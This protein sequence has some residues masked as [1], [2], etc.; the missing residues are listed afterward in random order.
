M[1]SGGACRNC[2]ESTQDNPRRGLQAAASAS[3]SS[4]PSPSLSLPLP[5]L[6]HSSFC[7]F[8]E[9]SEAEEL[10]SLQMK[11]SRCLKNRPPQGVKSAV[12]PGREATGRGVE[13]P[14]AAGPPLRCGRSTT[15]PVLPARQPPLPGSA[16]GPGLL[17]LLLSARLSAH[18]LPHSAVRVS[19]PC[20]SRSLADTISF[21]GLTFLNLFSISSKQK[22]TKK[23]GFQSSNPVS[24]SRS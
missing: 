13:P 11:G 18:C 6:I 8:G 24:G 5:R 16:S 10:K 1:D 20:L 15:V 9:S 7:I 22:K 19:H 12:V 3:S 17:A 4:R 2:S 21:G 23:N 14:S